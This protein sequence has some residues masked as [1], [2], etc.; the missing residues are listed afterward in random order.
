MYIFSA[1]FSIDLSLFLYA[2]CLALFVVELFFFI[3]FKKVRL[4]LQHR[5]REGV[6]QGCLIWECIKED[7]E[8][9]GKH[10][11]NTKKNI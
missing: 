7:A 3:K 11:L 4:F 10:A 9:S 6:S 5:M 1:A 2:T 8:V